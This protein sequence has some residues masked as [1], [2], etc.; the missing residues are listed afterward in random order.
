MVNA[1]K[2]P[3]GTG[4]VLM[5][6][7]SIL[8]GC[9]NESGPYPNLP[10]LGLR[11]AFTSKNLCGLG[12]SPEVRLGGVP[13]ATASYR[14]RLTNISVL[15]ATR[16]EATIKAE[17]PVIAEGAIADFV[18][19]CPGELQT[20]NYRLEIMALAGDGQPLAYGWG[21][22]S[23]RSLTRQVQQ[24]QAELSGRRAKSDPDAP[25]SPTRPPFFVQ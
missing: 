4:I 23:A 9:A 11:T 16:W 1:R 21:F 3:T 20:F 2:T 15:R 18:A 25:V 19:P 8:A 24:E 22:P 5:A 13:A 6:A 12:V 10:P 17:G 7:A 14:L